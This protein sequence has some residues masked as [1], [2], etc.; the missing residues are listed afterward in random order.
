ME[1]YVASL[2]PH[3]LTLP[4]HQYFPAILTTSSPP[5]RS[6][7]IDV[8]SALNGYGRAAQRTPV[9]FLGLRCCPRWLR[10]PPSPSA[11]P[12][13]ARVVKAF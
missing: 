13:V 10:C 4:E 2:F 9:V 8:R 11:S 7:G 6:T 5:V 3:F 12:H 1:R